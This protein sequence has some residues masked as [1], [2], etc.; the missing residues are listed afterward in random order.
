[1]PLLDNDFAVLL[2]YHLGH[3]QLVGLE[4]VIFH[5]ANLGQDVELGLAGGLA[6]ASHDVDV[7]R[8]VVVGVELESQSEEYEKQRYSR[9]NL[10][11]CFALLTHHICFYCPRLQYFS[12]ATTLIAFQRFR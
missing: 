2:N 10:H 11:H 9:F 7:Y 5:E 4:A 12:H 6:L 1:M 3:L 8:L